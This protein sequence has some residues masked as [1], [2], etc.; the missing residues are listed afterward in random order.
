[1]F[2]VVEEF[3]RVGIIGTGAI[4]AKH[5]QAYRNIGYEIVACTN[6]TASRGK[7]FAA[8]NGC[9]FLATADEVCSDPRVDFVDVCTMPDYRLQVVEMCARSGK[10]VLV[11]KPMAIAL[12]TAERMIA[13]AR[14]AGITLGVV[15]QHRFDD[16]VIFL[17]RAIAEGRLGEILQA[18]AYVKWYRSAEYYSRPIKGSWAIE[19]G[20]ALINQGIHQADLLLYLAGTVD[21]VSGYWKLGA[22]HP[23]ESEDMICATMRYALGAM[24]VIQATTAIWPGYPERIEIHGTKGT[25]IITGDKLTAW[26]V[27]SDVGEPA[28]VVGAGASG[29]SD[30]MAISL[31]PFERQLKD[32]GE[33]CVSGREPACSGADGYRALQLVQSIYTSCREARRVSIPAVHF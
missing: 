3:L 30:P 11:Q 19:G 28:P 1:M 18:D 4:A 25:A 6:T 8:A 16:S 12:D 17:R 13:V 10:H 20:G 7:E 33:A 26:D 31:V 24:G 5:A 32:F 2:S 21:E 23:I 14:D 27:K 9:E 22:L 15:S 29:A